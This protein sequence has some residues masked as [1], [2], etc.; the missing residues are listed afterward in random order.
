MRTPRLALLALALA[1]LTACSDPCATPQNEE[2][3][4]RDFRKVA[5]VA[6]AVELI[7][8]REEKRIPNT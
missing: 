7:L 2:I 5:G 8:R 4:A 6:Q 3:L 1:A